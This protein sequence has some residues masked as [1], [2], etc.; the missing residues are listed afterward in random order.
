[1]SYFTYCSAIWHNINGS[2]KHN[3]ERL[4]M[5]ALKC[6]SN[7]RAH[8]NGDDDYGLT[9]CNP[10]LQDIIIFKAVNGMLPEHISDLFVASNNVNCL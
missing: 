10:R 1:M 8:L 2:D 6:I 7:K 4:N 5:R 3:L 9:L